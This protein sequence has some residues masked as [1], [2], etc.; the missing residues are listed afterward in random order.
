[1]WLITTFLI[2]NATL[3]VEFFSFHLMKEVILRRV[4][5]HAYRIRQ[6]SRSKGPSINYACSSPSPE[7]P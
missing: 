7:A 5:R 1:M 6:R 2:K 4:T 3:T